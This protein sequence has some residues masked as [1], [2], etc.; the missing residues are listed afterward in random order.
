MD[1]DNFCNDNQSNVT[2]GD[3]L[4]KADT[5]QRWDAIMAEFLEKHG[6]PG[7]EFHDLAAIGYFTD[8]QGKKVAWLDYERSVGYVA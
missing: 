4:D 6:K 5:F 7:W 3:H 2:V 8:E 1:E